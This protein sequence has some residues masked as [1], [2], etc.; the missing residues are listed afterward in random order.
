[1]RK[2]ISL[3]TG[4]GG[5]DLG[6]EAAGFHSLIASDIDEHSCHSLEIN[7]ETA[8]KKGKPFLS[9]AQIVRSDITDISGE[10]LLELCGHKAGKIDL[11]SGGPPCQSFSIFGKRQ[12]RNDPRGMLIYHYIR[13]LNEIKPKAFVFENVYGILTAEGGAVFDEIQEKLTNPSRDISYN[14]DVFRLNA[15]DFGVPQFRDRVFIVGHQGR[16]KRI[17]IEQLQMPQRTVSDG[18]RGIPK[19]GAK[20]WHN[21]TGRKHSQRIIKRYGN[22]KPGE[23]DSF[24]R[25]NRLDL[26]RPSYAI[27]VGSDAGGGKGHVHPYEAREVTPRE[28]AR[29]QCF[30]DWWWFSG[31][32]RHP[33]RQI[34]NAVPTLLGYS[35][36]AAIMEH[37]FNEQPRSFV[38]A[39]HLLDQNHLFTNSELKKLKGEHRPLSRNLRSSPNKRI[40]QYA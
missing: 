40:A 22:M 32:T 19:M 15:A 6:L 33:I 2:T 4:G 7:K 26:K 35:V 8:K 13:I 29:M 3:F 36:G 20:G 16:R 1:M 9:S 12:G 37:I 14:I 21:H 30:P 31:T 24:T 11:L 34:G 28:S 17:S 39:L 10:T 38:E 23:R 18:L 5:L 25:V 27:I